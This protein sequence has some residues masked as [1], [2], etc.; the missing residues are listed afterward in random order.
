LAGYA[1]DPDNPTETVYGWVPAGIIKAILI[2]H[3][4]IQEGEVPPLLNDTEQCA[5]LAETLCELDNAV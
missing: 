3:N 2:K 5:I 4:G 1:E